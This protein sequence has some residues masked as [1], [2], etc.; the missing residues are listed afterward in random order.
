MMSAMYPFP[1]Y[2]LDGVGQWVGNQPGDQLKRTRQRTKVDWLWSPKE[3]RRNEHQSR[4]GGR[5]PAL[6]S[7]AECT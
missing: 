1:T 5:I 6:A 2:P 7:H 3:V 4:V